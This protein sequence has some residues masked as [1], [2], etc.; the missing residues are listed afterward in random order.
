MVFYS[1]FCFYFWNCL[2][3]YLSN[4]GTQFTSLVCVF[5][6]LNDCVRQRVAYLDSVFMHD[7]S[8]IFKRV[9]CTYKANKCLG[10]W[11]A[12]NNFK[13]K[14]SLP[15]SASIVN[16][17]CLVNITA[18]RWKTIVVTVLQDYLIVKLTV[19]GQWHP[20]IIF[21]FIIDYAVWSDIIWH[22]SSS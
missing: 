12:Q 21:Q 15:W 2:F 1:E 10:R 13:C 8:I 5:A 4:I 6:V 11:T 14:I 9:L 18:R 3:W 16:W 7:S 19:V 22:P 17:T 20:N